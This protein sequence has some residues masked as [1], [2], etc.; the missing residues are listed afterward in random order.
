MTQ[1]TERSPGAAGGGQPAPFPGGVFRS[2]DAPA[3]LT[4]GTP[5]AENQQI[6][7][8]ARMERGGWL[9]LYTG[10]GREHIGFGLTLDEAPL[11]HTV[12]TDPIGTQRQR[13]LHPAGEARP[14]LGWTDLLLDWQAHYDALAA[15]HSI[16]QRRVRLTLQLRG[17][18]CRFLLDGR[19]LHEWIP[20]EDLYGARPVVELDPGCEVQPPEITSLPPADPLHEPIDLSAAYN[21]SGLAGEA[22]DPASLP[23]G[24]EFA[25]GGVPFVVG[26]AARPGCDNLDIGLSWFR[27]GNLTGYEEPHRGSFGGRWTGFAAGNPSR[28]QFPVPRRPITALHLLAAAEERPDSIPRVTA[29]FFRPGAGFPKNFSSPEV[30]LA[31]AAAETAPA[32][33][34]R[35]A[36]GRTLHLWKVTIPVEP[37]LL[38]EL[39]DLDIIEVELTKDVQVYR[40]YP[41]PNHYSGYA[42]GL[43]SSVRVFAMTAESAPVAIRFDPEVLGNIWVE[44]SPSYLVTARNLTGHPAD[45]AL[46]LRTVSHDGRSGRAGAGTSRQRHAA[47]ALRP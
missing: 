19:L 9:R 21:A 32:W 40:A 28:F 46:T 36:S 13:T 17:K 10:R 39:E 18:L 16:R 5:L 34:V 7:I 4:I 45:V 31:T 37:G 29:Q 33:P 2:G 25:V 47:R 12:Y 1:Q 42:A 14:N 43:P 3:R 35:T 22:L 15:A 20:T 44:S 41:D 8:T 23:R 30:P 27:E 26:A 38:H 6:T 24:T 11:L